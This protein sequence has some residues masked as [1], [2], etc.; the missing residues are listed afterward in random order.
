MEPNPRQLATFFLADLRNDLRLLVDMK[1]RITC[2][3]SMQWC[4]NQKYCDWCE[5]DPCMCADGDFTDR[6]QCL[7]VELINKLN[8][9][10]LHNVLYNESCKPHYGFGRGGELAKLFEKKEKFDE[11]REDLGPEYATLNFDPFS[12]GF[13]LNYWDIEFEDIREAINHLEQNLDDL[14][15]D[16]M[17]EILRVDPEAIDKHIRHT[18]SQFDGPLGK[19]QRLRSILTRCQDHLSDYTDALHLAGHWNE[20]DNNCSDL[21]ELAD[22]INLILNNR[23]A[24]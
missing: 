21:A 8:C 19:S 3:G 7:Q 24:I 14:G 16:Q 10:Y 1:A 17:D 9:P 4:G 5:S 15:E 22:E 11:G 13:D 2:V 18:V 23:K 20:D 12:K 6:Q